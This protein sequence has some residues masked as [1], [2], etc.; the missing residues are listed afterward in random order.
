[1]FVKV[2]KCV[3]KEKIGG[4]NGGVKILGFLLENCIENQQK[5]KIL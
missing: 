1:M 2:L 3:F 5:H 4:I